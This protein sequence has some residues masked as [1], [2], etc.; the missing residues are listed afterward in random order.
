MTVHSKAQKIPELCRPHE[1]DAEQDERMTH[2]E[3]EEEEEGA[4]ES[5]GDG[6]ELRRG[7]L[8][9][10]HLQKRQRHREQQQR[11]KHRPTRAR[12]LQHQISNDGQREKSKFHILR[13]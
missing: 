7:E 4:D 13:T 1:Q 9:P 6:H 5:A 12:H 10:V 8:G 11:Q 2:G 3:E